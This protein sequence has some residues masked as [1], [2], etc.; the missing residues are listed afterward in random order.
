VIVLVALHYLIC[1]PPGT[2]FDQR[3][4]TLYLSTAFDLSAPAIKALCDILNKDSQSLKNV[5]ERIFSVDQP[6]KLQ[7]IQALYQTSK[8]GNFA[9]GR[10]LRTRG[11]YLAAENL[12]AKQYERQF[13]NFNATPTA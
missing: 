11:E 3:Y 4:G 13:Q 8:E 6:N 9:I 5:S 12:F 2:N 10:D 7:R 1:C